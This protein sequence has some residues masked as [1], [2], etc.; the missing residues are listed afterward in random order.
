MTAFACPFC[1]GPCIAT[2]GEGVAHTRP[3][4]PEFDQ[5][6]DG[7]VFLERVNDRLAARAGAVI[8]RDEHGE[9]QLRRN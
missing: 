3:T 4:C 2:S 9:R 8:T 7:L 6:D 1:G 5:A